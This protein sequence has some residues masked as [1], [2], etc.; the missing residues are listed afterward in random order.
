MLSLSASASTVQLT[1]EETREGHWIFQKELLQEIFHITDSHSKASGKYDISSGARTDTIPFSKDL[2]DVPGVNTKG[3]A[4]LKIEKDAK[5]SVFLDYDLQ[6]IA[7]NNEETKF[8]TKNKI[9]LV[10]T[11]GSWEDYIAGKT[12]ELKGTES[13]EQAYLDGRR[14][15]VEPTI[16]FGSASIKA[17]FKD[18]ADLEEVKITEL[19][20][21]PAKDTGAKGIFI[22]AKP[23]F[24]FIKTSP[25]FTQIQSSLKLK[26]LGGKTTEQI[27]SQTQK[28]A[29]ILFSAIK[30]NLPVLEMTKTK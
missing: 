1:R 29:D 28:Y 2:N 26:N 20:F 5:G 6:L 24:I 7:Q 14:K 13:G 16:T 12:V 27:N 30:E 18:E 15:L 23:E 19:K 22:T 11:H 21:T 9:E 25:V 8:E 17:L 4:F 10:F 3:H